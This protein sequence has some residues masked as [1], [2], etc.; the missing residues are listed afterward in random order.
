MSKVAAIVGSTG[1]VGGYL[2]EYLLKSDEYEKVI[3]YSRKPLTIE[4]PK[5]EMVLCDLLDEE[6]FTQ[7]ILAEDLFCCIGTTQAKTPD[8]SVYKNIDYGIPVRMAQAGF[9]GKMRSFLVLSSMGANDQSKIFYSRIKGQ[10]EKTLMSMPIP[11]LHIFRP[12]LILGKRNE[13]RIGE[14][15]G[16][17]FMTTF[18]WLIPPKYRAIQA[19]TIAKAMWAVANSESK[20]VLLESSEIQVWG[21]IQP[22]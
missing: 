5:L 17:F 19:A 6:A 11:R 9:E 2:L 7:P 22:S 3:S 8:L 12:S 20:K 16:K 14:I 4:H 13:Q 15:I 21:S 1:L 18:G 10:M